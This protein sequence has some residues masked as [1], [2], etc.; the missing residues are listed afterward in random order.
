MAINQVENNFIDIVINWIKQ[1]LQNTTLFD[2]VNKINKK[3]QKEFKPAE[4]DIFK[5]CM[6]RMTSLF[7]D[8]LM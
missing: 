5:S 7:R 1:N 3:I 8:K 4:L 2:F 6:I